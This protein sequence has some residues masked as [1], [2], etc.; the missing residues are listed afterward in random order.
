MD[1]YLCR[2]FLNWWRLE[3][4]INW[5]CDWMG[6]HRWWILFLSYQSRW[7]CTQIW[8]PIRRINCTWCILWNSSWCCFSQSMLLPWWS[9]KCRWIQ[10]WCW[11]MC[12]SLSLD[13]IMWC[14]NCLLWM[15]LWRRFIR[16]GHIRRLLRLGSKI[17]LCTR[18]S[19]SNCL[20][21]VL[22]WKP[23]KYFWSK[24]FMLPRSFLWNIFL[25]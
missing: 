19:V 12:R 23:R 15:Q 16:S 4:R 2:W 8:G 5:I 25:K 9:R 21:F 10:L 7:Y 14:C 17:Y 11:C 24:S 20:W 13:I 3:K 6:F 18:R 22:V 1:G